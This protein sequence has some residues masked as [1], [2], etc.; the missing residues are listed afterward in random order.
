[1]TTLSCNNTTRTDAM[2]SNYTLLLQVFV[3][4][5]IVYITLFIFHLFCRLVLTDLLATFLLELLRH[6]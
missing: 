6:Y 2:G 4:L 1:M 5:A 3:G